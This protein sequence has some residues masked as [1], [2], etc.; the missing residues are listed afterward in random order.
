MSEE[1]VEHLHTTLI[2]ECKVQPLHFK[3]ASQFFLKES[4]TLYIG[5]IGHYALALNWHL[6]LEHMEYESILWSFSAPLR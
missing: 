4:F 5:I 2:N 1:G 6:A 3:T